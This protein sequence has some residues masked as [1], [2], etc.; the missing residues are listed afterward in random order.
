MSVVLVAGDERLP[1]RH[2]QHPVDLLAEHGWVGEPVGSRLGRRGEVEVHYD[3][4]P[5]DARPPVPVEPGSPG[6]RRLQRLGSYAIVVASGRLLMS[7]L[8]AGVVGG[9]GRWTLPG[10]GVD[11]GEE[12][13]AGL[14]REVH[15]ETGQ[16]VVPGGLVQVQSVHRVAADGSEDFH[17][18]RLIHL[19]H[20]PDPGPARVVEVD[21]STGAAAW[22]PIE[23]VPGLPLGSMMAPLWPWVPGSHSYPL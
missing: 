14:V 7:R 8:A 20:C 13:V 16:H 17:A 1:L 4:A 18:V 19:A 10:G 9:A 3:V 11:P 6:A 12:P 15:E 22:V 23:E 2:G 21:G 5:V